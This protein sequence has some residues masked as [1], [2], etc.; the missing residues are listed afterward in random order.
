MS[1]PMLSFE[2]GRIVECRD[3]DKFAAIYL[4]PYGVTWRSLDTNYDGYHNGSYEKADIVF[5]R[6]IED[7][8]DQSF[9]RWLLG[10]GPYYLDEDDTYSYDLPPIE[11][12]MQWLCNIGRLPEGKYIV[13]LWW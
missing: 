10:E 5:G 12:M 9:E 6:E 4:E 7:D 11:A 8:F 3:L 2:D 13:E 1:E